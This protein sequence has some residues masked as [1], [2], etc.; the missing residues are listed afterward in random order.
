VKGHRRFGNDA[1]YCPDIKMRL[2]VPGMRYDKRFTCPGC[3][4]IIPARSPIATSIRT[5][6]PA[7]TPVIRETNRPA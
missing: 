3:E 6:N 5:A 2:L 4:A 7:G 1:V